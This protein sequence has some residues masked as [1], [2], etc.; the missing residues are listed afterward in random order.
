MIFN[1]AL[2]V[3]AVAVPVFA[4]DMK[5]GCTTDSDCSPGYV[6]NDYNICVANAASSQWVPPSA[7]VSSMAPWSSMKPMSTVTKAAPIV[8]VIECAACE[9]GY[10]TS[11]C[12]PDVTTTIT[13]CSS[14]ISPVPVVP[15]S[16]S[17]CTTTAAPVVP[18]VPASSAPVAPTSMPVFYSGAGRTHVAYAGFVSVVAIVAFLL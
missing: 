12:Y 11:T 5:V 7:P 18:I 14:C 6:C 4:G 17:S 2:A 10:S 8:T 15:A 1:A 16:T 3:L 13:A 9:G